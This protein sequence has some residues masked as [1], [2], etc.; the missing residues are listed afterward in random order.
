MLSQVGTLFDITL[1]VARMQ[2]NNK[3]TNLPGQSSNSSC[4]D[5]FRG[6]VYNIGYNQNVLSLLVDCYT[7]NYFTTVYNLQRHQRSVPLIPCI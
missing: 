7:V 4:C 5:V 6:G 1:D 2:N 3:Q